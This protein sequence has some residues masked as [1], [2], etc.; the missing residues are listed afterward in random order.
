VKCRVVVAVSA[1]LACLVSLPSFAQGNAAPIAVDDTYTQETGTTVTLSVLA[2]DTDADNDTLFMIDGSNA[3]NGGDWYETNGATQ[4][5]YTAGNVGTETFTYVVSDGNGGTDTG[6]VTITVTASSNSAPVAVDDSYT[7]E[8]GSTTVFSVLTNDTDADSDTLSITNGTDGTNGGYWELAGGGTQVEYDAGPEGTAVFTYQVSDGNGGTD[9]GTVTV[10][11]TAIGGGNTDPVAQNDAFSTNEATS[12]SGNL[13]ADNGSGADGDIDTG[14]TL[15][16]IE[17]NGVGASIGTTIT[18]ASG[19]TLAV[20]AN[21][22]FSYDPNGAFESLA[23]SS[24]D[25]DSFTYTL[26]DGNGGQDSATATATIAGLNDAPTAENDAV[27]ADENTSTT[28]DV[29]V[30]NGAGADSDVDAG[31]TLTVAEVNGASAN[32][33]SQITL[34][35]GALLTLNANGAFS[36]DPNGA[37]DALLTGQSDTDSFTYTAADGN[38]G[39][40][41]ATVTVTIAGVGV[42]NS[43]P[44]ANDDA[45]STDE[46]TELTGDILADN[47]SGADS[48]VDA[49]DTLSV[50]E[51]NGVSASVGTA[52]T[53]ASGA[54]LTVNANGA[55]SYDPNGVFEGLAVGASGADSFAYTIDDG[56]GLTDTATVSL[57]INGAND[58]P[59]AND[60]DN[61]FSVFAGGGALTLNVLVNDVDPDGDLLTVISVGGVPTGMGTVGIPSG[62]ASVTYTPDAA[63]GVSFTYTVEDPTGATSTATVTGV[64]VNQPPQAVNDNSFT[65]AATAGATVLDVLANDSDPNGDTLIVT[66]VSATTGSGTVQ[67]TAGGSSVSYTP[68]LSS[69][70]TFTY[71]VSDGAGGVDTAQVTVTV[72]NTLPVAVTDTASVQVGASQILNVLSNDSDPDG[73]GI[74]INSVTPPSLGGSV[75]IVSGGSSLSYTAG[76]A[77]SETFSYT[78]VD[79]LGGFATALV[80]V[81]VATPPNPH[82]PTTVDDSYWVDPN[83]SSTNFTPLGNDS[84]DDGDTLSLSAV[85]TPSNGGTAT[86]ADTTTISYSPAAAGTE[87]FSY[88][89]GDGL[90]GVSQG[91]VTVHVQTLQ[92]SADNFAYDARGRLTWVSY[93]DNSSIEYRYDANNNR[94]NLI[95]SASTGAGSALHAQNDGGL[96]A[97]VGISETFD[98]LAND[99]GTGLHITGVTQPNNGSASVISSGAEI[100]YTASS[101]GSDT[102]VYTVE[103]ASSASDTATVIVTVSP[104]PVVSF[105]SVNDISISEG[106]TLN[107]TVTRAGS[108]TGSHAVNYATANGTAGSSDYVATSGTA[109]F[110]TGQGTKIVA[111]TTVQDTT[112]EADETLFLNLSGAT[113]GSAI[114]DNQGVGVGTIVN[115]DNHPPTAVN[116]SRTMTAG[117]TVTIVALANDTDADS[118]PLSI[119]QLAGNFSEGYASIVTLGSGQTVISFTAYS[120]ASGY[121]SFWYYISDGNGGADSAVVTLFIVGSGGEPQ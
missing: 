101:V 62:S 66:A 48:D 96:T 63:G 52:I 117:T 5:V 114:A 85:G 105:F 42:A 7:V 111:V 58:A 106:G 35:S 94:T 36:Y 69:S 116:D 47:G 28:G 77:G 61:L 23:A 31:D 81:T 110:T 115:D 107:F 34:T 17:V 8:A 90:G 51:V 22:T 21:G 73:H 79:A 121:Q 87:T 78:I 75:T 46:D 9:W 102:F 98:V 53:L 10:T 74:S 33:G 38:G 83:A 84:D 80:T 39:S 24:S 100:S 41:T 86:L 65:V 91:L 60:D 112:L 19:A 68:G 2:N 104:A 4:A 59:V 26:S 103:D 97:A 15:S 92:Q 32:V 16:V 13:L 37:F 71:T 67:I 25:S 6:T 95:V 3:S 93:H 119:T 70:E 118:D 11:V 29:L 82:A 108:T 40:D 43:A 45:V 54:T 20:S 27:S 76:S 88:T 64:V 12:T 44:V 55:F 30:D 57:T 72:Q 18:L 56:H 14:D 120:W 99:S 49:G 89:V 109:T 113:S 50:V 1:L